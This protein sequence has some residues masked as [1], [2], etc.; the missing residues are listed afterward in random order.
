MF[1]VVFV[2][3]YVCIYVCM[4]IQVCVYIACLS[5]GLSMYVCTE[6]PSRIRLVKNPTPYSK[7]YNTQT[8]NWGQCRSVVRGW[9]NALEW[10]CHSTGR[11][12]PTQF[13]ISKNGDLTKLV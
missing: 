10:L 1:K 8:R 11:V 7:V 3:R 6:P 9:K 5:F 13:L 2:L 4:C 12:I